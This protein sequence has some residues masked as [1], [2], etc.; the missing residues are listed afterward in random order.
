M[1]QRTLIVVPA[2]NEEKTI[3]DVLLGLR[4]VAPEFDRVVVNDGSRDA[5]ARIVAQLGENQLNLPCNLGYGHALQTGLKYALECG[6]DV[7]VCFDADGQHDPADVPHVVQALLAS[8]SDMV[9][10]SRYCDGQAYSETVSRRLGQL[11]FSHLSRLLLGQRIYDTTSGFKAIRASA[12]DV[13]V[14][15][16]FM[17]F[18]TETLVALSL[19]GFKITEQPITIRERTFGQSMHSLSS[20]VEYPLKTLLLTVVAAVDALLARRAQ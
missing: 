12:C 10:G 17:D 1:R 4:R 5:T 2:Y 15:G 3:A 11:L 20:I 19:L 7:V 8:E 16:T 9:I 14:R 6:Y 18:H 13:L